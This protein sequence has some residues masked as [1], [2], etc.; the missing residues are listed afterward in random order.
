MVADAGDLGLDVAL[1]STTANGP[2]W[3]GSTTSTWATAGPARPSTSTRSTTTLPGR[4]AGR[5]PFAPPDPVGVNGQELRG[6]V[7]RGLVVQVDGVLFAAEAM[8]EAAVSSPASSPVSRRASRWRT[9]GICSARAGSTRCRCWRTSTRPGRRGAGG[10]VR[11]AGPRLPTRR[12][13]DG[14]EARPDRSGRGPPRP[15]RAR[16]WRAG[17]AARPRSSRP[18]CRGAHGSTGRT[19]GT[20]CG[21][22]SGP[23]IDL[24]RCSRPSLLV[25]ALE[26]RRRE[27]H[28]RLRASTCGPDLPVGVVRGN[29][30]PPFREAPYCRA[31]PVHKG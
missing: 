30:H 3:S 31:Q 1:L 4:A 25:L 26:V 17:C 24:A 29:Q 16:R 22:R 10:T 7:Q 27:E 23:Q 11:I 18:R 12:G 6:M 14:P 13:C 19:A 9:G 15:V 28:G 21:P 8:D 5:S 2:S 20:R